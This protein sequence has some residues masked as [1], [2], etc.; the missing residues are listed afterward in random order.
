VIERSAWVAEATSARDRG[1]AFFDVLT[2]V[3]REAEGFEVVLRL[4]SVKAREELLLITCC[5]RDDATVPTLTHVFAGAGWHERASAELF[6]I[7]F[8]G[9]ATTPLLLPESFEGHPL[10]KDFVLASRVAKSWPGAKEPGE[11][12]ADLATPSRR[13]P[14][15]PGVPPGWGS[16]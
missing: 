11:S 13:R 7:A 5:P 2:A 12:S 4:W 8:E 16:A 1:F 9:H 15:P 14:S 3:D 6:G 10:R